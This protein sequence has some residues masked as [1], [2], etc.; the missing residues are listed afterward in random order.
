MKQSRHDKVVVIVVV[1]WAG[2]QHSLPNHGTLQE[3]E[4]VYIFSPG[5]STYEFIVLD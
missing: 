5:D 1:A 4:F 3:K 2:R